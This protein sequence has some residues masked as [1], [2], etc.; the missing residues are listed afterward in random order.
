MT[1]ITISLPKELLA[2]VEALA[3]E[4]GETRSAF[5]RRSLEQALERYEARKVLAEAQTLY[6]EIEE[7]DRKLA[8][9]F[10]AIS[11]ETLPP[12]DEAEGRAEQ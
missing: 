1:R 11:A 4:R 5:V 7:T 8:E 12:Y 2:R 6:A 3:Q 9:G 10:L